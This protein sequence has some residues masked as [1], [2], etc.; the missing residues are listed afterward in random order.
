M[1]TF[2]LSTRGKLLGPSH[3]ATGEA[4][5]SL[6]LLHMLLGDQPAALD[7]VSFSA[8]VYSKHL[9]PEHPSTRDVMSTLQ[10]LNQ[11]GP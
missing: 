7:C 3:I 9:G 11:Q 4:K 5:F 2:I 8:E 1:L 6:G 10:E